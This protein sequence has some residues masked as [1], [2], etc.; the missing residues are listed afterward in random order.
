MDPFIKSA[1][2]RHG[3]GELLCLVVVVPLARDGLDLRVEVNAGL[4]V[5]V[6][7]AANRG[8]R[9]GEGE[10]GQW[11]GDGDVHSDLAHIDL[12]LEL[13]RGRT[14]L[15]KDGSSIAVGVGVRER[16]GLV[17]SIH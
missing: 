13:A 3:G 6:E 2:R 15:R 10:E 5:K 14:A 1:K 17:Q 7:I 12:H 11:D 8:A 9:P 16:D 4:A